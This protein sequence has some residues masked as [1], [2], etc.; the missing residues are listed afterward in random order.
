M[1]VFNY[2]VCMYVDTHYIHVG[3]Y[4]CTCVMDIVLD[5]AMNKHN[6]SPGIN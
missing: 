2:V 6:Y 3:V 5:K 1:Y 4:V